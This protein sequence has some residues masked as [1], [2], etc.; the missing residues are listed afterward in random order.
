VA[1]V[2][3]AIGLPLHLG[4]DAEHIVLLVL[5]LFAG[6]LTLATGRTTVLQ[7]GV[8]LV[9]FGAFLTIAAVP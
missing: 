4:L 6:T 9:I 8:H 1:V 2:S 7:G 5:T 3:L